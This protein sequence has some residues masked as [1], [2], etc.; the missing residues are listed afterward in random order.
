[1]A[2]PRLVCVGLAVVD[3]VAHVDAPL[4]V[5]VKQFA[6][7]LTTAFGGPATT[8]AA[9]AARLDVDVVLVAPIGDD[10]R[11]AALLDAL[12]T[13]GIG[14][15]GLVVRP[16]LV[17]ATSLV[18]VSRDGERTIVNATSAELLAPPDGTEATAIDA[19]VRGADAVLVDVRWPSA[20]RVALE[21][22]RERGIPALLDLDRTTAERRDDVRGLVALATHVVASQDGLADVLGVAPDALEVEAALDALAELAGAGMVGV[23]L[24]AR[25]MH[26]RS[27]AAAGSD[28][29]HGWVPAFRVE[30]VETLGAGDVWHGAFA[31]GLARGRE[32]A[33][34]AT[35]ASAAAALRCTRR[36]GWETLPDAAEVASLRAAEGR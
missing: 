19:L 26:W 18:V 9:A 17:S 7:S 33:D 31:A 30:V 13:A 1:M 34:A 4:T 32:V 23:T 2:R 12:A 14:R 8:A 16:G 6:A 25:G 3:L 29:G 28:G 27:A 36:G 10:E 11:A 20:A 21:A 5:G 24:G 22:A 15:T 35:D